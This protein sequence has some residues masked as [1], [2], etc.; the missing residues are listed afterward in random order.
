MRFSSLKRESSNIFFLSIFCFL[1]GCSFGQ[2]EPDAESVDFSKQRQ[3]AV[4]FEKG[5]VLMDS[6]DYAGALQ[7]FD[8]ILV[9][10]PVS[11]L[12]AMVTYNAGLANLMLQQCRDAE[13]QLRKVIRFSHKDTPS[14]A[15]RARLRLSDALN[16]LGKEREAMVLLLEINKDRARLPLEIGEAELPAK[17]AAAYSRNGNRKMAERYFAVAEQGLRKLQ[18]KN[19]AAKD[20]QALLAKTLFTMGDTSHVKKSEVN[21]QGYYQT[22]KVQQRYLL[23]AVEY[24]IK[25]WSQKAY[26]QLTNVYDLTW[27]FVQKVQPNPELDETSARRDL[28]AQKSKL[29]QMAVEGLQDLK[30]GKNLGIEAPSILQELF[31]HLERQE[32]K[33]NNYLVAEVPG[34]EYTTE[35]VKLQG[36]KREGR[37]KSEETI[38]EQKS[39]SK[40]K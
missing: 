1:V 24:D 16:C 37:V 40:K 5:N 4:E 18:A 39:N 19:L 26:D 17:I 29:V 21:P 8:K 35:A 27:E 15:M 6:E 13:S 3:A 36:P 30:R 2:K 34:S 14:L 31:R 11:T 38:L 33:L 12:D 28:K 32:T 25:P 9:D 7:I 20:K 22:L 23:R 10:F